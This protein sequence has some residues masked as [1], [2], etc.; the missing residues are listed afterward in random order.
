MLICAL[1]ENPVLEINSWKFV[2]KNRLC[3]TG[4]LSWRLPQHDLQTRD[5]TE[6][7][8]VPLPPRAVRSQDWWRRVRQHANRHSLPQRWA[9]CLRCPPPPPLP[10]RLRLYGEAFISVQVASFLQGVSQLPL[11]YLLSRMGVALLA[12]CR[13]LSLPRSSGNYSFILLPLL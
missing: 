3:F 9:V 12:G 13:F 11:S 2:I 4:K 1:G 10:A 5:G 8:G 6:I 7:R